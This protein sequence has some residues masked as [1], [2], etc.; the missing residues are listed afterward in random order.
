[1]AQYHFQGANI[2]G[3]D[4]RTISGD[5]YLNQGSGEFGALVPLNERVVVTFIIEQVFRL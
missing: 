3:G 5:L 2:H 1:M 4:F